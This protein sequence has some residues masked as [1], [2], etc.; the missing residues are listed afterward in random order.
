[1][2]YNHYKGKYLNLFFFLEGF[3]LNHLFCF[4]ES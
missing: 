4:I 3:I 2:K 1:M